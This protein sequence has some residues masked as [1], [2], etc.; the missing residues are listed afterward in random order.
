VHKVLYMAKMPPV[1]NGSEFASRKR[2]SSSGSARPL[3]GKEPPRA[4]PLRHELWLPDTDSG[5]EPRGMLSATAFLDYNG[6]I[7]TGVSLVF[8]SITTS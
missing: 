7:D 4:G 6:R 2:Y 5:P 3:V 8:D 1:V